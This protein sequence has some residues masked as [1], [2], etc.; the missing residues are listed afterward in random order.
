MEK[1][2]IGK[3]EFDLVVNG[4]TEREKT[5]SFAISSNATYA[6]IETAFAD[7]SSIQYLSDAGEILAS[8]QDGV[9]VKTIK[10]D[11]ESGTYT[12]DISTDAVVAEIKS[13]RDMITA[14]QTQK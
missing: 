1:I 4:V 14:L 10:R 9:S 2:K 5:R 12:I 13:L 7:V 6:D 3:N 8:Y 11:Y